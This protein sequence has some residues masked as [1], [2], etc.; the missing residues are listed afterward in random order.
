LGYDTARPAIAEHNRLATPRPFP[1]RREQ[2]FGR[3][4]D[5]EALSARVRF[6]GLTAV[7]AR[8]QMGKSWLLIELARRLSQDHEPRYLVGFAE[9]VGETP[10]LLLRTVIDLYTRWLSDA[11]YGQQARMVW[12]QQKPNLLPGIA[13]TVG[14]IFTEIGAAANPVAVVVEE[15][16]SGLISVDQTLKTGGVQLP[17]LSYDQARDLVG[18]VAAIGDR[19]IAL[20]LDQW[21]KSPDVA[22]E[23]KALDALI[24]HLDDWPHCHVFLALRP[25]EPAYG[26]V[27]ELEASLRGAVRIYPLESMQLADPAEQARLVRYVERNVAAARAADQTLLDLVDGFPGVIMRWTDP[28]QRT[29]MRTRADLERVAAEA[30]TYRFSELDDLLPKLP[31]AQRRLAIRLALLPLGGGPLWDAIKIAV[32]DHLDP[33]LID[34]LYLANILESADPP[35]FG[36]AKRWETARAWFFR[37]LRNGTR[38][39]AAALILRVASEVREPSPIILANVAVLFGLLPTARDLELDDLPLALCQVAASLF[40]A[41]GEVDDALSRGAS[42]ARAPCCL[43]VTPLLAMGLA[44]AL[45]HAKAE[46]DPVRRDAL[47]A[48][49]RALAAA[50]LENA[51]V[52]QQL[53]NGLFNALV[54]AEDEQDLAR[55]DGLLEELRAL[56]QAHPED[57]A[58]REQLANGLFNTLNPAKEEQDLA[59]RDALLTELRKLAAAHP[60]DA[61]VRQCLAMGLVHTLLDPSNKQDLARRKALVAELRALSM[62][63]PE[64]VA[65]RRGLAMG[66]AHTLNDKIEEEGIRVVAHSEDLKMVIHAARGRDRARRHRLLEEL[67]ALAIAHPED[68]YVREEL[69]YGLANT[70]VQTAK[71]QDL[72]RQGP[73]LAALRSL[74]KMHPE[75]ATLREQLA[76]GLAYTLDYANIYQHDEQDLARLDALLAELRALAQ[77]FPEDADL[78]AW[79]ACGLVDTLNRAKH[80]RNLARRDARLAELQ[81]LAQSHP[82]EAALCERLAYGFLKTLLYAKDEQDLARRDARLAELRKLAQVH[83]QDGAGREWLA[84]GLF[85]TL[86]QAKDE[87]DLARRDALLVELRALARAHPKDVT[88]REWLARGLVDTLNQAVDEQD[89]ARPD[90]LLDELRALAAAQPE[91]VSVRRWLA[92]GLADTLN[93]PNDQRDLANRD[94]LLDELRALAAAHPKNHHIQHQMHIA[95]NA[96]ARAHWVAWTAKIRRDL[97]R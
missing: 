79:L 95:A 46:L 57:A 36:H 62:A 92:S 31:D 3:E 80:E 54:Y 70:L 59:R 88:V 97:G 83:P 15:A 67:R 76:R 56:A 2:L 5:L 4:S 94:A 10:D 48:E 23:A 12:E 58:V 26:T 45:N 71:E 91:G 77:A 28:Y 21:E 18:A 42:V 64:D 25:D 72:R 19:P 13:N 34:D 24:R 38:D 52:R 68:A 75:E 32:L 35:G 37:H 81:A 43:S 65:V 51:A 11:G 50:H 49:L 69:A 22:R 9:S 33:T 89:L 86:N 66:L 39:E 7:A 82:E 40:G 14:K 30:Q 55:R 27:Q 74:A 85:N 63:H 8:P 87:Q 6:K 1:D 41:H 20:F 29:H 93:Q 61:A 44:N 47:L 90:A 96:E 16:I 73:L 60:K 53:A 78:R 17:T 84:C